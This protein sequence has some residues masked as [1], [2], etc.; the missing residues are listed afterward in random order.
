MSSLQRYKK[1]G[2]FYQLLSLI[3]T[4]GPQKKEKFLE[5]IEQESPVWARTIREKMITFDRIFSWPEQIIVEIFKNLQPKTLA[6]AIHGLKPEQKDKIMAYF[7]HAE[8]RRLDD[9]LSEAAPKPEEV[10]STLVKVVEQTRKMLK[11]RALH[12]D[13]FDEKLLIAEDI[14]VK[15][16]EL[17]THEQFSSMGGTKTPEAAAAS[18][19]PTGKQAPAASS[20]ASST[21]SPADIQAGADVL[22]LQRKIQSL[23]KE[24]KQL[25]DELTAANE[26]L[27][28]IRKMSKSA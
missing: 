3:E 9:M 16:E 10:A 12:A 11:E 2:G 26:K 17:A 21:P 22:L 14:E 6:Y 5:M 27:E 1:S 25:K 7:S 19:A 15:L 23:M 24:N 18:K 8:K 4:F 28:M 13:K 20:F